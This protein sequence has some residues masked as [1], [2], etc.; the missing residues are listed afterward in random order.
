MQ[1]QAQCPI[2]DTCTTH[3]PE[4]RSLSPGT[5]GVT[6]PNV[7]CDSL[8]QHSCHRRRSCLH[9]PRL[10]RY[11]HTLG[12]YI[13]NVVH[14]EPLTARQN[15]SLR[16]DLATPLSMS[17]LLSAHEHR[18]ATTIEYC[19]FICRATTKNARFFAQHGPRVSDSR[20]RRDHTG[21]PYPI[22]PRHQLRRRAVH[23][24]R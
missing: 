1:S 9:V 19:P 4:S 24:R 2:K 17:P 15:I 5:P 21:W 11:I 20:S 22:P 7:I 23:R 16:H 3:K 6:A 18:Q 10:C 8:H 12:T 13:F 14:G